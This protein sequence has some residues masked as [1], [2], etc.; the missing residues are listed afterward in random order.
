MI[1]TI[2]AISA[3]AYVLQGNKFRNPQILKYYIDS[4]VLNKSYGGYAITGSK[5]WNYSPVVESAETSAK[6]YGNVIWRYS[7]TD[8]GRTVATTYYQV[9]SDQPTVN[10]YFWLGFNGLTPSNKNETAVHEYGHALG[11]DHEDDV[12]AVMRTEGFNGT[13]LPYVDDYN[14]L[15]AIY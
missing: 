13:Y 3:N 7:G 12:P 4:T 14:G 6:L 8:K 11:L 10:I 15:D 1:L 5:T 9:S 2:P